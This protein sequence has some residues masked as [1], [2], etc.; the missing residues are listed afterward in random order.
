MT[1]D[2]RHT[3]R[4]ERETDAPLVPDV[5][6]HQNATTDVLREEMTAIRRRLDRLERTIGD[7]PTPGGRQ[8]TGEGRPAEGQGITEGERPR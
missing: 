8:T 1:D 3:T 5:S 4:T 2:H 7:Q 6:S